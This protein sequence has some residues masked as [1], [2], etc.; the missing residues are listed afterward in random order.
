VNLSDNTI[1]LHE[2]GPRD[3]LQNEPSVLTVD[4]RVDLIQRLGEAGLRRIQV[5]SFVNPRKVPQMAN[6]DAVWRNLVK[7]EGIRYTALVL[8]ERGLDSAIHAGIPHVEVYVSAS[9]THSLKNA[10]VTMEH[11]RSSGL[12]MIRRSLEAGVGVTA[13]V[14]CA[15]GCYYEG[16]VP[17]AHVVAMVESFMEAGAR[18]IALADTAGLGQ[19]D[20]VGALI[21]AVGQRAGFTNLSLHLHDTHGK[22]MANLRVG[23]E[24]GVRRFDTAVNGLGGCPFI[25]DAAGNIATETTV[26]VL[27]SMGY[28]TTVNADQI[29]LIGV[30]LKRLLGKDPALE[31]DASG[32]GD[33][34]VR[35][36]RH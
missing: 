35:A 9:P 17:E 21:E 2:V 25:P 18:E 27:A 13:G 23:L 32:R 34:T 1:L 11:A 14:M 28:R 15:F 30:W 29:R 22:A 8:N 24:L 19:P 33:S 5:G 31:T 7:R 36:Q 10:G 26:E 12:A 3:G 16:K 4:Q 6:T 20:E